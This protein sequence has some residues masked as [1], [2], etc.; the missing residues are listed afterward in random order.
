MCANIDVDQAAV[1]LMCS[2]GMARDL[3][4]PDDRLVFPLAGADA[5]DHF[6]FSKR[7]TLHASPAIAAAGGAALDAAGVGIDDVARFDLYSCFP[8]AVEIAL[9]A[10]GLRGPGGGDARPLTVT[11]GLGFAGGPA[12][13]YPTHAIA[14]M[15]D[16]CRRDPGSVGMVSALGWYATKHSIGLYSTTPP[17]RGFVR[18]DNESTQ[19]AVDALPGRETAGACSGPA[20][21]EATAVVFEREGAPA[22]A[23]VSTLTP[24][25]RRAL[26][27]TR[28][29]SAMQDMTEKAW[30]GRRVNLRTDGTV[31]TLDV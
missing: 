27:N 31:N 29:A 6:F 15:V 24:D 16:A 23:I 1:L 28:D 10:L 13:D 3:R 30:E 19:S 25:G 2:Y 20:T 21:V 4:V 5:H 18:A 11:G 9:G 17:E 7:D 8:S 14:G 12:N 22:V 26:A